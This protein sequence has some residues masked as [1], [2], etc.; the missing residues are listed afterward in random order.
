[1][2]GMA[3]PN[4]PTHACTHAQARTHTRRHIP[5]SLYVRRPQ[6]QTQT[7][8]Q[9][10]AH[11]HTLVRTLLLNVTSGSLNN[12]VL[13]NQFDNTCLETFSVCQNKNY[14][15][16]HRKLQEMFCLNRRQKHFIISNPQLLGCNLVSLKTLCISFS[17]KAPKRSFAI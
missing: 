8:T 5:A 13:D 7:Q 14:K 1:M 11:T 4:A 16:C 15:L 12:I 17:W 3:H 9:T 6:T 2:K 10:H